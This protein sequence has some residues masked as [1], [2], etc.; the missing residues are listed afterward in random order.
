MECKRPMSNITGPRHPVDNAH[1][2][3]EREKVLASAFEEFVQ[4]IVAAGWHEP[5][6]A[7]TMADIA[8][9]YVI[10]LAARLA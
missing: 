8:D 7:L 4:Q 6:I 5:E 10:T 9:D 3:F 1:R 2:V